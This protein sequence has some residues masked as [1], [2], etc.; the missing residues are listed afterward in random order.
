MQE[1]GGGGSVSIEKFVSEDDKR[2]RERDL[3]TIL[4]KLK[5]Q[6]KGLEIL[7]EILTKD[8]RDVAIMNRDT[9]LG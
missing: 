9:R 8:L 4:E 6:R 7:S 2:R 5:S 1:G 3:E